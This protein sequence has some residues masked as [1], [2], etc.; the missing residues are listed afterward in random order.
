MPELTPRTAD[1]GPVVQKAP[2]IQEACQELES[3][4]GYLH[5]ALGRVE[6]ALRPVMRQPEPLNETKMAE[7]SEPQLAPLAAYLNKQRDQIR[8]V[9]ETLNDIFSRLEL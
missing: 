3:R 8:R 9:A 2:Q 7:A 5:E 1:A 6:D 4:V